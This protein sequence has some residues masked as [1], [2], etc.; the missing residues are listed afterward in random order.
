ME[1]REAVLLPSQ[2]TFAIRT[3]TRLWPGWTIKV[4][5][6]DVLL[7]EEFRRCLGPGVCLT[8][9]TRSVASLAGC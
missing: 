5:P 6:N 8:A 7:V 2:G 3:T 9:L 1:R 4:A